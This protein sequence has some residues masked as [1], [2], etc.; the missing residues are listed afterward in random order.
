[1]EVYENFGLYLYQSHC[2]NIVGGRLKTVCLVVTSFNQTLSGCSNKFGQMVLIPEVSL[3]LGY[4]NERK[5][6]RKDACNFKVAYKPNYFTFFPRF[7]CTLHVVPESLVGLSTIKRRKRRDFKTTSTLNWI[8]KMF[9]QSTL[10][11]EI[12]HWSCKHVQK[13]PLCG[14]RNITLGQSKYFNYVSIVIKV[15]HIFKS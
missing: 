8:Y 15:F 9:K 4:L 11:T 7:Y 5:N 10:G 6:N 13:L 12:W 3:L 2:K 1:M 14:L